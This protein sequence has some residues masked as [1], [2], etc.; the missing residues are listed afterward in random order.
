MASNDVDVDTATRKRGHSV[1]LL[2]KSGWRY[3]AGTAGDHKL[4]FAGS[5]AER[6]CQGHGIRPG[7][8][9]GHQQRI[10]STLFSSP[11]AV[12]LCFQAENALLVDCGVGPTD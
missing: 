9:K 1:D 4:D 6:R 10:N 5:H 3:D 2:Y 11:E 7:E 8:T 12:N